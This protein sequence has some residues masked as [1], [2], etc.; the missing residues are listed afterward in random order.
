MSA[1]LKETRDVSLYLVEMKCPCDIVLTFVC[2][3]NAFVFKPEALPRPSWMCS[4]VVFP[5]TVLSR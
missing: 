4:S 5:L 2:R 3:D 1:T